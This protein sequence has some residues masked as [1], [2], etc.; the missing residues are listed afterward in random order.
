MVFERLKLKQN[1]DAV[2]LKNQ[3]NYLNKFMRTP[4]NESLLEEMKINN[5]IEKAMNQLNY[6]ESE[7][8][9]HDLTG[10]IGADP[11]FKK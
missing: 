1:K 7:K 2:F 10:T 3:I 8:Y 5:Q 9:I 11:L 6:V 4:G